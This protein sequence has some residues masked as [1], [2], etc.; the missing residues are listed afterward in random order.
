MSTLEDRPNVATSQTRTGGDAVAA[1]PAPAPAPAPAGDPS[2]LGLPTFV[3]GSLALGL[4]LV[5]Y[6]PTPAGG[7]VLPIVLAATGLGLAIATVWAAALAQTVVAGIFGIFAGFW[8]SYAALVLGLD[9]KWFAIPTADVSKVVG[10]FLLCWTIL[11]AV[12]TVATL[13]LPAAF[14]VLLALVTVALALVTAGTLAPQVGLV[15]AGGVVVL[16]FA[17]LGV[18]LFASATAAALGGTAFNLGRPLQ[19]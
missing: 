10:T 7:G 19:H 18:Y 15:K 4:A 11:V 13:R 6:L 9:H 3:V 16:V 17:A 8:W 1:A 12:L 5:G 2:V 14:S